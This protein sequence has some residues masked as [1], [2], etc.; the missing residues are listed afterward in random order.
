MSVKDK[1]KPKQ[2]K[3]KV[4]GNQFTPFNS[5]AKA[6][7]VECAMKVGR[8]KIHKQAKTKARVDLREFRLND[9]PFRM[10]AAQKAFNAFIRKRDKKESCICCDKPADSNIQWHAGHYLTTGARPEHRFNEMN[11]HKQTS[12]CNNF[13]SGNVAAYR[14]AL[15]DKYG[16][17]AVEEMEA[18][19][20]AKKYTCE[21][22]LAI[23]QKY[24]LKLKNLD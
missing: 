10:K 4:C 6:C 11:C 22:L 15:I 3:C 18:N 13:N 12:Y 24:K 9:K 14:I 20:Q 23:E 7:S 5:M 8:E 2:K 21:D 1:S 16:L 17:E 19:H